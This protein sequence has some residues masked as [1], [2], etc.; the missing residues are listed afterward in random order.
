MSVSLTR[1]LA[2]LLVLLSTSLITSTCERPAQQ[3]PPPPPLLRDLFCVHGNGSRSYPMICVNPSKLTA[4]PRLATVYDVEP[5][6]GHPSKRPVTVEWNTQNRSLFRIE[7]KQTNC[8]AG[9]P[10]CTTT[11]GQC[12]AKVL[13][14]GSDK[15]RQCT[16]S[17]FS[18]DKKDDDA[19]IVVNPCCS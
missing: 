5:D 11:P 18:G 8:V 17:M 4:D 10:D 2:F 14:L 16:Y 15:H 19:T 13:P 12:T 6:N 1:R 9:K 7:F 3:P